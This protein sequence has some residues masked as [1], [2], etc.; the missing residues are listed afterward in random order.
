M[1]PCFE[2]VERLLFVKY[3][4][5]GGICLLNLSMEFFKS[6]YANENVNLFFRTRYT[7]SCTV[8]L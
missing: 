6:G 8:E 5:Q 3:T 7:E 1:K 2:E 4:V